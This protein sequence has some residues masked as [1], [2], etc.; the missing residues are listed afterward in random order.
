[1]NRLKLRKQKKPDFDELCEM[2]ADLKDFSDE[3]PDFSDVQWREN[4]DIIIDFQDE[5]GSFKLF[6]S[7]DIPA[8]ARVDFC[9]TPTYI[10]TAA[11]MKAYLLD[12][13]AFSLKE[14]SALR[15]GLK[16][17]CARKLRGHGYE[18]FKGQIEA[19]NIFMKAG[20]REFM[21]LH[22]EMCP[23]FSEMCE[24]IIS[25]FRER[26]SEEK[27]NGSWGES[28]E[29]EI[30][31][32]NEYFSS[33]KVFVY[34]TLMSG[35]TNHRYLEDSEC[36]GKSAIEGYDMYSAGWYPAIIAG[37]GLI[38]GEL[39]CVPLEDMPAIDRLEGEGSLYAKK[40]ETI[41]D[42]EL[43]KTLAFVYVYLEDVSELEKIS[44]WDEEYLWYVSYGSNMLYDRFMCYI[45]GGSFEKSRYHPPCEDT[46]PPAAVR[47]IEMPYSM[48]FGNTSGSW[49]GSGVSFLDVTCK[50][51]ALGVAY[52]I[53]KK[54]FEHV[55]RRENDGRKPNPDYGWYEDV[56]SL[57]EMDGFEMKTVTNK[58]LR[59]YNLPSLEYLETLKRGIRQN[60]PEMSEEEI[61][62]YLEGC[63]RRP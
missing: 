31:Q 30:K 19:L 59:P 37:D 32:I 15:E 34:G 38:V 63:I 4:L 61:E 44:A 13:D 26:E 42:A 53:T 2:L 22:W 12:A 14:K 52:L 35:Q 39:Y 8:D 41:T 27:F 6:D 9:Y 24:K 18:A 29:S 46:A 17:S 56:I 28:Y 62:E 55:C 1:M 5:D 10:C 47:D 23:E 7:F 50:G 43:N 3:N 58:D 25:D 11:L 49:H 45:K 36:I 48:Y 60:W 16:M 51:R 33:R 40:C 20:L 54:Q 21:D 57:G